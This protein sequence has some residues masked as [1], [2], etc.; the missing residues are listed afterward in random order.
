MLELNS[1]VA[2]YSYIFQPRCTSDG[3]IKK[4]PRQQ[5]QQNLA[6]EDWP[7]AETLNS[8][9]DWIIEGLNSLSEENHAFRSV[10]LFID[11]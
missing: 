5:E 1:K 11:L 9:D 2:S 10:R 4:G 3:K 7:K 6:T 8:T